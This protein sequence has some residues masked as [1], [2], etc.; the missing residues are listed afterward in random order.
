VGAIAGAGLAGVQGHPRRSLGLVPLGATG[1]LA[2]LGWAA[3]SSNLGWPCLALG[4]MSG[5]I[6]VPLRAAYQAAVP[7]D[8]R[9]NGMAIMNT[10]AYALT[11]GMSVLMSRLVEAHFLK[12]GAGQLWFLAVLAA[13]GAVVAWWALLRDCLEQIVEILLW[14][15]FR[16]RGCGPGLEKVPWR[17]PVI[18]IANHAAYCDPLWLAKVLPRR[19]TPMMTSEFF[20]KPGL[21]FLMT[22]IT[23]TIRVQAARFRRAAPELDEAVARLDKG[24]CVLIFPEGWMRRKEER[25]LK[26]FGQGIWHILRQRPQTPVVPCWIEGGWGSYTSHAG[27]PP[28]TNKPMD[29]WRPIRVAVGEP[30]VVDPAYLA[31][32]RVTRQ[33]LWHV[34]LEMRK[35][36]S[37]PPPDLGVEAPE[38][39]GQDQ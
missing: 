4:A 1:L 24:E 19:I 17:G 37:L 26:P 33:Y 14:P 39:A 10:T 15:M 18:V 12:T 9:G 16:I 21:H 32:Q 30:I 22:K 2:V 27:G 13:G 25:Q 36:L 35:Y 38:T 29:L 6:N 28:L 11:V 23:H 8:A 20:D 5:L 34:C 31:D 7:P 3:G